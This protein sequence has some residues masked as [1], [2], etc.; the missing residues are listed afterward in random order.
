MMR[1]KWARAG[2]AGAALLV[3][4]LAAEAQAAGLYV[5]DRGVR[6]MGRGGAFVAGADDLHA[7]W[8]NPAGI[9]DAGNSLLF[10]ATWVNYSADYTR[11]TQVLD[12]N[13]IARTYEYPSVQSSTPFL[14]IPTLAASHNFGSRFTGAI[15]I[16]GPNA[17]LQSFPETVGGQPAASRYS[18]ISMTGSALA[19][20]SVG[21]AVQITERFKVGANIQLMAGSFTSRVMFNANPADR[22]LGAPEDPRYDT[23]SQLSAKPIVAPSGNL[24]L[25]YQFTHWLKAG[26]SGQLPFWINAPAT[27]KTRLPDVALFDNAQQ[28]GNSGRVKFK[29]PAVVRAGVEFRKQWDARRWLAVEVAYVREFWSLHDRIDVQTDDMSLTGVVGFPSP[30][31]VAP[32]S[33]PR[34]F[35]DANSFRVGGEY[36]IPVSDK[37]AIAARAGFS[38]ETS[39]IDPAWVS[40]LT[41][42][43]NKL[44]PSLGAGVTIGK[45][46]RIDA[47]FTKPIFLPIDVDPAD[48]RVPRINPVAGNPTATEAINGGSYRVNA[49]L[50]GLGLNYKY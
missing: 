49:N 45:G 8:Y 17:A 16:M 14:P 20:L 9:R 3:L 24:G 35:K 34:N 23:D 1:R 27:V 6:S 29:L 25:S 50:I 43:G 10:D 11:R 5:T 13:G 38:Y 22:F 4:L 40:P 30:F 39:A 2:N 31:Y 18:L 36:N 15:G 33:I 42:D 12:G 28:T 41:I 26:L 32:F 48:A 47:V 19:I 7:I 46:L 37:V 44:I 21:G